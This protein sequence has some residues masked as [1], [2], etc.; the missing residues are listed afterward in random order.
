MTPTGHPGA[1]VES[2]GYSYPM[3]LTAGCEHKHN[4][5]RETRQQNQSGA[6][7]P[8]AFPT[9]GTVMPCGQPMATAIPSSR[10]DR[11]VAGTP[12]I[13][14]RPVAV[15]NAGCHSVSQSP[16]ALD[17]PVRGTVAIGQGKREVHNYFLSRCT[18]LPSRSKGGATTQRAY[19]GGM[20]GLQIL[21]H[22]VR[23]RTLDPRRDPKI[24][25][26][27]VRRRANV[28]LELHRRDRGQNNPHRH[29]RRVRSCRYPCRN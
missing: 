15:V 27:S 20:S 7:L 19:G 12:A 11:P 28:A 9:T 26:T 23:L 13:D 5:A 10:G 21:A 25:G 29:N 14:R 2:S 16:D 22:A 3:S 18:D 1:A 6:P 8:G 24:H 4:R 17:G